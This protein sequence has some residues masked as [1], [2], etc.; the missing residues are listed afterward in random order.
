MLVALA[1]KVRLIQK[2]VSDQSNP[3]KDYDKWPFSEILHEYGVRKGV[4]TTDLDSAKEDD[5]VKSSRG[6][7]VFRKQL[8]T[9]DR[10]KN[11]SLSK[12]SIKASPV[13]QFHGSDYEEGTQSSDLLPTTLLTKKAQV[14]PTT[15]TL[16]V[17]Q[18]QLQFPVKRT[19]QKISS[20]SDMP[21]KEI[22]R[23]KFQK[24]QSTVKSLEQETLSSPRTTTSQSSRKLHHKTHIGQYVLRILTISKTAQDIYRT[25]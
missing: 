21:K 5:R 4:N 20:L 8:F 25:F 12:P 10:N 1:P 2:A 22:Q 7:K 14:D 24:K 19:S 9:S 11:Y 13:L 18:K 15:S 6:R 17:S 23:S 16:M 3:N